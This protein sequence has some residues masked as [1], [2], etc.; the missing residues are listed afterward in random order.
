MLIEL[1]G[2]GSRQMNDSRQQR[3]V[4]RSHAV[5]INKFA[6]GSNNLDGRYP[7]PEAAFSIGHTIH[8]TSII[9]AGECGLPLDLKAA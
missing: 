1:S 9:G 7:P 4:C 3:L 5:C 6:V 2:L 8:Q